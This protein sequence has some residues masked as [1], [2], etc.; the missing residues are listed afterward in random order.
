VNDRQREIVAAVVGAVVGG[1]AGYMLFTDRGRAFRRRLEPALEDFAREL[2]QLRGTVNR[3]L[4]V[5]SEGWH[6]LNE[7]L[8]ERGETR[9][10][11]THHQSNPF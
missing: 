6:V 5:A 7:A 10:F 4:G 11:T 3:A 1:M 8:G 9:A 2:V